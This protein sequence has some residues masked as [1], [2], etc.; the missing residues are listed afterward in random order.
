MTNKLLLKDIA[1]KINEYLKRFEADPE[2]NHYDDHRTDRGLRPYFQSGAFANG[3]YV[4]LR[5]ISYQGISYVSK[6]DAIS[7]L[8]WLKAGNVGRHF[9]ALRIHR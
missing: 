5:Y 3:R 9:E 6:A 4:G 7:Y 1:A 8:E 2:I